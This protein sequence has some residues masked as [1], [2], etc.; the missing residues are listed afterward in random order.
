MRFGTSN[1]WY[2]FDIWYVKYT[3]YLIFGTFS[4]SIVDAQTRLIMF[5]SQAYWYV[6]GPNSHK[7]GL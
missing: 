6:S 5:C 7:I 4:A 2:F 3:K 1:I